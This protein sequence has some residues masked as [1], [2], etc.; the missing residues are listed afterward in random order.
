MEAD[1]DV[2][3]SDLAGLTSG[4]SSRAGTSAALGFVGNASPITAGF[5]LSSRTEIPD[6]WVRKLAD[7]GMSYY[8][9]NKIT[10]EVRWTAPE[11]DHSTV[12]QDRNGRSRVATKSSTT[13]STFMTPNRLRSDSSV[14]GSG[15]DDSADRLSLYSNDSDA[16]LMEI[17]R[18][19][20]LAQPPAVNGRRAADW[21]RSSSPEEDKALVEL[22]AAERSAQSL[23]Q[24]LSPLPPDSVA[25]LSAQAKERIIAVIQTVRTI[26]FAHL[27]P[28]DKSLDKLVYG[29][30]FAIRNLLY[31]S[32]APSG[33]IPSAVIPGPRDIRDRR[34]TTASQTLLKPA[35]RK[36]TATL[37]KLVL[38]ARA[39]QYNSGSNVNDTP[40]RIEGDAEELDRAVEAFVLEVERSHNQQ[41]HSPTELKRLHGVFLTANIGLGLVGA[42][43]AG[44]WKG[45]GWVSLE[46]TD[47]A[48]SK[49]LG[50]EVVKDTR[51]YVNQVQ[52]LFSNFAMNIRKLATDS[53][54]LTHST[55]YIHKDAYITN[56]P[57]NLHAE[58]QLLTSQLSSLLAY[59]ANIHIARHVDIDGIRREPGNAPNGDLYM[60]T[61][62]NARLH[63]RTLEAATQALYDDGSSLFM[64]I[65]SARRPDI[66]LP[67]QNSEECLQLVSNLARSVKV[68]LGVVQQNLEALLAIGHDQADI[69]QGDYNG[70]IEWRMSRLSVI[71]TAF[72]GSHR[73]MSTFNSFDAGG[74][75]DLVDMELAFSKPG[76]KNA[77][78]QQN[79]LRNGSLVSE[80]TLSVSE[81]SH[82]DDTPKGVASGDASQNTLVPLSPTDSI[83]DSSPL[84]DEDRESVA[85]YFTA[86]PLISFHSQ[87]QR[88]VVLY[89]EAT[90][91][92]RFLVTMH[93]NTTSIWQM[94]RQSHG[95]YDRHTTRRKF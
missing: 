85:A 72:G 52:E 81:R 40:L 32:A 12:R 36:V 24:A 4:T 77:T 21:P 29:V 43:A 71:D 86:L 92:K 82:T 5:G 60:Q 14:S 31:V 55:V 70:S 49:I 18:A 68:N 93:L 46:E 62:E 91:S 67:W 30:V 17:D 38:S 53:G 44:S 22:T 73:P 28:E 89:H 69:A 58:C 15:R 64:N 42:G 51:S 7:D 10:G 11:P 94:L 47:E 95:I 25:D 61:V 59:V 41:I 79:I 6:P 34:D 84:F 13:S 26:D 1:S 8:F 90:N 57:V 9:S 27:V 50:T 16:Y 23:Q 45:H 19:R 33:H 87:L 48:P 39:V 20:S 2:S 56:S 37:S 88:R 3:D 78:N 35:Q 66:G 75:D 65:Q 63:I 80:T 83:D 54:M 74:D 76:I